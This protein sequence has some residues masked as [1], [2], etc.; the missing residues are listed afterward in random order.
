MEVINV[1][2]LNMNTYLPKV[3]FDFRI[4]ESGFDSA[5]SFIAYH[6]TNF[7]SVKYAITYQVVDMKG[8]G[9]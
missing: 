6:R 7:Q 3:K 2:K 8:D 5:E 1:Q 4:K 9:K